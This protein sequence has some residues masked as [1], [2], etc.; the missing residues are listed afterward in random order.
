[1]SFAK[2][3]NLYF[4]SSRKGGFGEED[5]YVSRLVNK[6]YTKPENLGPAINSKES[7]YDP[8]ISANEDF[9]IFTSSGRG[10]SF[11]AG[12]RR[13]LERVRL[14]HRRDH[15]EVGEMPVDI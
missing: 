2:N 9:I 13:C 11:G 4:A 1:M 5:I 6:Q 10:D 7:E 14:R 12:E 15:R 3:G 8:C